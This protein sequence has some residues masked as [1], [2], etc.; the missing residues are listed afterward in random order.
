MV[1]FLTFLALE[2]SSACSC[3]VCG[4]ET[5]MNVQFV[6][7]MSLHVDK[8]QWMFSI[9]CT[10][11]DFVTMEEA[12]MKAHVNNNHA[13]EERKTPSES[14]S[15]SSSSLSALS[16]SANSKED[17]DITPKNK[18]SNNLLVIS[19]VPGSQ[20]SVNTEE[21]SEKG[22]ALFNKHKLPPSVQSIWPQCE[23]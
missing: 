14:N 16:D 13:A 4:F 10:A 3:H 8:E 23:D 19:V 9:C 18:G 21:K 1:W 12:D 17:A 20:T 6:S 11:C 22:K 7:H 15:P 2:L 5:E